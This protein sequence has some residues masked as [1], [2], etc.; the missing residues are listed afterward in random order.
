MS[1][2]RNVDKNVYRKV[3]MYIGRNVFKIFFIIM[4]YLSNT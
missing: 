2:D 1:I 4:I 3:E